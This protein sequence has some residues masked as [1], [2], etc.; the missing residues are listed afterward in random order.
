MAPVN[1]P[2]VVGEF[3]YLSEHWVGPSDSGVHRGVRAP[4]K[5]GEV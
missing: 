1:R 2:G 3:R 5:T 4:V